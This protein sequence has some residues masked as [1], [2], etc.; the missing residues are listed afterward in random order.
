MQGKWAAAIMAATI[1]AGGL[2]TAAHADSINWK[3]RSFHKNAVDVN[4]H[5]QNRKHIWPAVGRVYTLR[6]FNIANMKIG[7]VKGE[8]ICYGAGVK[9]DYKISWGVGI[10]GKT[11]CKGCCQ[12]CNGDTQTTVFNLNER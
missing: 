10:D 8:Q 6:D 7:C 2:V 11:A 3:I 1:A 12:T 4:F 5:S 9:G